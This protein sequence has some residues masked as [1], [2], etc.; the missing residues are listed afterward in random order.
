MVKVK[1]DCPDQCPWF[2]AEVILR[3]DQPIGFKAWSEDITQCKYKI[4]L[5]DGTMTASKLFMDANQRFDNNE[6]TRYLLNRY[7]EIYG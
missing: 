2:E 6:F 3:N 7:T 1:D 5:P 4:Y